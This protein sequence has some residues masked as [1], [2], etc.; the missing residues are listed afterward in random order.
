MITAHARRSVAVLL[1]HVA[2]VHAPDF[3]IAG[4]GQAAVVVIAGENHAAAGHGALA[5]G[6][7]VGRRRA[8]GELRA[9]NGAGG[10]LAATD[11]P[12]DIAHGHGV[13]RSGDGLPGA[14]DGVGANAPIGAHANFQPAR[15]AIQYTG[16]K[17]K[18]VTVNK[19]LLTEVGAFV[20]G[21]AT[22]VPGLLVE[23]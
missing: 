1:P 16:A 21:P 2:Q 18:N 6:L 3:H 12:R 20:S 13:R 7:Q 5:A 15:A 4:A 23:S 19:P 17:V 8:T 14:E 11:R 9:G 10:D 22:M